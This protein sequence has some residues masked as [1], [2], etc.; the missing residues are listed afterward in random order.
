M[1]R[2]RPAIALALLAVV[3]VV[4]LLDAWAGGHLVGS[5]PATLATAWPATSPGPG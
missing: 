4:P 5:V 3:A 1:S 2:H